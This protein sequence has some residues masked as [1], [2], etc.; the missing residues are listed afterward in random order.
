[1]ASS[2]TGDDVAKILM[3]QFDDFEHAERVREDLLRMGLAGTDIETFMLNAPGQHDR[4][5]I[6]GDKYA[7]EEAQTG[8]QGAAA[9]ATMGGAAGLAAGL[10]ALPVVG[11]LAAGVGVAIGAY[12]GSL[13]GAVSEMGDEPG[14]PKVA[15]VRERPAGVRVAVRADPPENRSRIIEVFDR[16]GAK[17]IEEADGE[18][19]DGTWA[20][21]D[22]ISVP[23][24]VRAPQL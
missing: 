10:A 22:P 15:A 16:H 6:G 18:W 4:Y 5:P 24:W 21:F 14:V 13:A 17:S 9:G 8:D 3:A 7:D 2:F 12:A 11:P 23:H 1:L 20:D 19:R